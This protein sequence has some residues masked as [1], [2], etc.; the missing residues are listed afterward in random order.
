MGYQQGIEKK[1]EIRRILRRIADLTDG[2]WSELPIPPAALEQP[3]RFFSADELEELRGLADAV[4]VPQD[5]I[6]EA[7]NLAVRGDLSGNCAQVGITPNSRGASVLHGF[8]WRTLIAAGARGNAISVHCRAR[9]GSRLG[10]CDSEF[11]GNRRQS[12]GRER[13]RASCLAWRSF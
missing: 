5:P 4:E 13:Q 6:Y 10:L 8:R 1:A 9:T 3:E 11:A 12:R 2:D 7:L